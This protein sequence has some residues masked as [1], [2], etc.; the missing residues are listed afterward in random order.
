MPDSPH[1]DAEVPEP[2]DPV[3]FT[4]K[5]QLVF[6][7]TVARDNQVRSR[8]PLVTEAPVFEFEEVPPQAQPTL[9][10]PR[11]W[12]MRIRQFINKYVVWFV[13]TLLL[14]VMAVI[15]VAVFSPQPKAPTPP[16]RRSP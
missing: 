4:A 15:I 11:R 8:I 7:D 6:P 13:A 10:L 2:K 1:P 16:V 5:R 14:S 12:R 3:S 9:R